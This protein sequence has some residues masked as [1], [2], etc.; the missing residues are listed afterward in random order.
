MFPELMPL[1]A[2]RTVLVTVA[3]ESDTT[4]GANAISDM[5]MKEGSEDVIPSAAEVRFQPPARRG[6]RTPETGDLYHL[7]PMQSLMSLCDTPKHE[8]CAIRVWGRHT[9]LPLRGGGPVWPS[10]LIFGA[11]ILL[12]RLAGGSA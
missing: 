7:F 11:G 4:I 6:H 1:L 5:V 10:G 9:G 2:E 8:N 12:P 3:R